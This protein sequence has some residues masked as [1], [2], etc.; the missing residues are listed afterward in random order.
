MT[1]PEMISFDYGHT[2]AAEPGYD[3][4]RGTAAVMR[5]TIHN[6]QNLTAEQVDKFSADLFFWYLWS[7]A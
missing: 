1:K 3:S 4:L 2:L 7:S 6:P 5:H